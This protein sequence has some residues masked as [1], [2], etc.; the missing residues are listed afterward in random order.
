M[1][2]VGLL[3]GMRLGELVYTQGDDFEKKGKHWVIN[4]RKDIVVSGVKKKRPLK[5]ATS[6]RIVAVHDFLV[7]VG[8]VAWARKRPG[9]IF[10]GFH[11]AKDPADAASKRMIFWMK[12]LGIH[13]AQTD[14]FHALRHTTKDWLR[15]HIGDRIANLQCGHALEGE[16]AK[17]G[18]KTLEPKEVAMVATA[19]LPDEVDLCGYVELNR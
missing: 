16:G 11:K 12:S 7:E 3:T 2:L 4:L 5:T 18:W 6:K 9:F 19:P 15:P 14:V 10:D 13:A 8:F 17:Y 1:P